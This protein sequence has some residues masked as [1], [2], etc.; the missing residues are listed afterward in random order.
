MDVYAFPGATF[1][2]VFDGFYTEFA[3]QYNKHMALGETSVATGSVADRESWAKEL[4]N[5]DLSAYPC[6]ISVTWFE[7]SRDGG[8]F[9]VIMGQSQDTIAETLTNFV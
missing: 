6:F 2:G 1:A 4:A 8:Y 9:R 7:Y 5:N 3:R